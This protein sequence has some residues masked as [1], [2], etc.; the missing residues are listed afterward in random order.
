MLKKLSS[1]C[2]KALFAAFLSIFVFSC[3]NDFL[4]IGSGLVNNVDFATDSIILPVKAYNRSFINHDGVQTDGLNSGA[5][6]VYDDPLYGQATASMLSTIAPSTFPA[7]F[8]TDPVVDSVV[9]TL[10]YY[11]TATGRTEDGG[12]EYRLDSVY[13]DSPIRLSAYRSNYFLNENNPGDVSK[14]A[15]Y[16]SDQLAQF[17]GIEGD[18]LFERE[19][20]IPSSSETVT[21]I[22]PDTTATDTTT[23]ITRTPPALRIKLDN[24]YWQNQIVDREGDDV[25]F[26]RSNFKDYFRGIYFN[27]APVNGKGNY[28][29]FDR[30]S[31]QVEIFYSSAISETNDTKRQSSFVL[32]LGSGQIA[33]IGYQNDFKPQIVSALSERDTVNGDENLYLKGGQ[34]S[35][36]VINLFGSDDD[37]DGIPD[38]LAAL[39]ENSGRIIRD[40]SLVF[41]INKDLIDQLGGESTPPLRLYIY[42]LE[43]NLPLADYFLDSQSNQQTGQVV[44][45]G[46]THLVPLQNED[47]NDPTY[48]IRITEHIKN[49]LD[50]DNDDPH[51]QL[52]VVVTQNP[53]FTTT[54]AIENAANGDRP[55]RLPQASIISQ[56]GTI[57][58]GSN[59]NIN[60]A[61]RLSLELFFTETSN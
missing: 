45:L 8:G 44:A 1:L 15:V 3:Q 24:D 12:T 57:L 4:E 21:K 2:S 9:L 61:K 17:N 27:A 48:R 41:H 37:N 25:L 43:T 19:S 51:T 26:N 11:S 34:G 10:P 52:G 7:S 49:L 30:S 35:M 42:D 18:T 47:S 13:G 39:R 33:T 50:Q 40:A 58:Y 28:F 55:S 32:S 53:L 29:L 22:K 14:S 59:K 5:L 16:Y 23:Q 31:A 20:F 54:G 56:Q 36:A 46:T 60:P 6:G 38:E